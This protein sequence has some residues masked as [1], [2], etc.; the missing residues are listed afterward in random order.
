MKGR[1]RNFCHV[2]EGLMVVPPEQDAGML[3]APYLA[4]Q[5]DAPNGTPHCRCI[6]CTVGYCLILVDNS[7]QYT[8]HTA[9]WNLT[10]ISRYA[11]ELLGA[12]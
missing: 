12:L 10:I 3:S 4:F 1:L 6:D 5:I 11:L 7:I 9:S 2:V 8:S